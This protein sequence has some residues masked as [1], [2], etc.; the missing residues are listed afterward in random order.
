MG[1][2]RDTFEQAIGKIALA[3]FESLTVVAV[4]ALILSVAAPA[5]GE[6]LSWLDQPDSLDITDWTFREFSTVGVDAVGVYV[7]VNLLRGLYS[8]IRGK[9]T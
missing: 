3:V 2:Q 4:P 8:L 1:E 5:F 9:D 7:A 6:T